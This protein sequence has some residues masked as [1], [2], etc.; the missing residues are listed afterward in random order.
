MK[1]K[2]GAPL[3]VFLLTAA[4]LLGASRF[5]AALQA[6]KGGEPAQ[7]VV[8]FRELAEEG[9]AG[10]QT[11]LAVLIAK[12]LG[13]PQDDA[14]AFY[15]AW[16]ARLAGEKR[17]VPMTEFL[18]RRLTAE[19]TQVVAGRLLSD[20]ALRIESGDLDSMLSIGRVYAQLMEPADPQQAVTW[21][22]L[23]AA[24][25][26]P[27][28]AALRDSFSMTLDQETRITAQVQAKARFKEWCGRVPEDTRPAS[29]Q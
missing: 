21:F 2:V 1:L 4:P 11:N 22:N 16:R 29:C 5:Q 14:E 27:Y 17:A 19:A 9:N 24:F 6:A 13:T 20:L 28:A 23:A 7:A 25:N 10:A 15:W 18:E 26:V 3:A 8:M 12:G